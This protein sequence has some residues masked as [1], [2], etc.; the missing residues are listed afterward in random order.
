MQGGKV[1][2]IKFF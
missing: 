2:K 1:K